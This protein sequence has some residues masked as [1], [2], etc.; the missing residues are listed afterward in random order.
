MMLL[1]NIIYFMQ[2]IVPILIELWLGL[3]FLLFAIGCSCC[4]TACSYIVLPC[5]IL[6]LQGSCIV[7]AVVCRQ[8]SLLCS[9][10]RGK[11]KGQA[12][13]QLLFACSTCFLAI[14]PQISKYLIIVKLL[15]QCSYFSFYPVKLTTNTPFNSN[16]LSPQYLVFGQ[17]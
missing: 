2:V 17:V 8:Y 11:E 5:Y 9:T 14:E 7:G 12:K 1:Q 16:G 10:Y 4:I 13:L 3:L 15:R 6:H